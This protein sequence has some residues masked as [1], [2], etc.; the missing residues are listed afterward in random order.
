MEVQNLNSNVYQEV[1]SSETLEKHVKCFWSI[2]NNGTEQISS[3][4]SSNG[5][6]L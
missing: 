1:K 3:Y 5:R 2:E 6:S 4:V